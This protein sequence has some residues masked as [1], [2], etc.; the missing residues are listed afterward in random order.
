MFNDF[1]F[2]P[3]FKIE[4]KLALPCVHK[5]ENMMREGESLAVKS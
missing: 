4:N 3:F 5:S 1:L 2:I